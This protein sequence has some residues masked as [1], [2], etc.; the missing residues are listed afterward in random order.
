MTN[1]SIYPKAAAVVTMPAANSGASS[2]LSAASAAGMRSA[3]ILLMMDEE[4]RPRASSDTRHGGALVRPGRG[5]QQAGKLVCP[6][7]SSKEYE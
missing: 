1:S 3:D 4:P 5:A 6:K 7:I 2:P